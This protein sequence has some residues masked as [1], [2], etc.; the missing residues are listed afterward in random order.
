[1]R[2]LPLIL[3]CATSMGAVMPR[4]QGDFMAVQLTEQQARWLAEHICGT[5]SGKN[6]GIAGQYFFEDLLQI[7]VGQRQLHYTIDERVP[8]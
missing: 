4:P 1:V 5:Y 2:L 8:L 6:A 7:C 3:I